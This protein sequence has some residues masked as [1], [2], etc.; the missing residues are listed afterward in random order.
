MSLV[1]IFVCLQ[2]T[3]QPRDALFGGITNAFK[4][5]EEIKETDEDW[6]ISFFDIISLYPW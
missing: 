5:F 4:L 2:G 1:C 6:E 3:I